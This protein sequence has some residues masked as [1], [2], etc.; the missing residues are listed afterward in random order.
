MC[1]ELERIPGPPL[2]VIIEDLHLVCDAAWLVP[3]FRRLFFLLPSELHVLITSRTMPPTA[4]WR[5]RSKQ[6]L[7]VIDEET[8]SFTR[9]EATALFEIYDLTPQ[10]ASIA[11]DHSRGRAAALAS[12]AATLHY[13]ETVDST[14]TVSGRAKV[15]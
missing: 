11:Y 12:L 4:L 6:T 13:A 2:L 15:S 7:S 10:Q 3:F 5:M 8:L 1:F 14:L 9:N